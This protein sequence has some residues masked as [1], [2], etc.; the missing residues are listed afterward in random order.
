VVKFSTF[1]AVEGRFERD[2]GVRNV[3]GLKF[4]ELQVKQIVHASRDFH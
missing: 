4:R 3:I 1:V 2:G